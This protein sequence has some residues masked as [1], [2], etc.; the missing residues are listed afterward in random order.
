MK[1]I[2]LAT[3]ILFCFYWAGAQNTGSGNTPA[4]EGTFRLGLHF[5]PTIGWAK[6]D[7][8]SIT[9]KGVKLGYNW[10]L[11]TDIRFAENYYIATGLNVV[12][13]PFK[14]LYADTLR[15]TATGSFN[16]SNVDLSYKNQYIGIPISL[17]LKTKEINYMKYFAQ[18]GIEPQVNISKKVSASK[19]RY[20]G[21]GYKFP[22]DTEYK[23]FND[24]T[25]FLRLALIVG[26][27][28]EYSL[29]GKTDLTAG[30]TYSNGLTDVSSQNKLKVTNSYVALTL[31]VLF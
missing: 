18:L 9:G 6:T 14:L 3:T 7:N 1:N 20:G 12:Q 4:P 21:E 30:I 28:V 15:D 11:I 23:D 22:K 31:G 25:N 2:I 5:T 29:G 8:T 13:S 10:G 16:Q 26:A 17:K 24:N 27:G 19:G